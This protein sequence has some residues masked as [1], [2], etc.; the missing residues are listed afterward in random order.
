M[1]TT[2]DSSQSDENTYFIDTESAAEMAR[3]LG[4]DV[5]V[6]KLMGGL[7]SERPDFAGI[8]SV[9]DIGCGPG[10]WAI[11]V[12]FA[13]PDIDV[14]GI[15]ISRTMID[16]ANSRAQVQE[17][18]NARFEV[19]DALKPLDFP[20]DTFD[21]V[22]ARYMG[23]FMHPS[24]WPIFV[25]E[26]W[27]ITCPGGLIRLTEFDEFG[28]SNNAAF[29]KL[30]LLLIR[31]M[32]LAG[33][34]FSTEGRHIGITPRLP[35]FLRDTGYRNIQKTLHM[36]DFSSGT[37][38]HMSSYQNLRVAIKLLEPF[39]V[40]LQLISQEDFDILYQQV[41]A[42]MLSEDFSVMSWFLSVCAEK[43]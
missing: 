14:I 4:Q 36:N 26:C 37:E 39:V 43:P 15:D 10:G 1:P 40:K 2:R 42:E 24:Q 23:G 27:R 32:Q 18:D 35:L 30:A 29:E 16:Y 7:F 8:H 19:M 31:A 25:Q 12:A 5:L 38:S 11:E 34:S 3:L 22:N 41:M 9:L 20:D 28:V 17:L 21:L 13:H 6:T 33:R